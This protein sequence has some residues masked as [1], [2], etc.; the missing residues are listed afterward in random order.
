MAATRRL[1][2]PAS[3]AW[4]NPEQWET[5]NVI[6]AAGRWVTFRPGVRLG[7][8]RHRWR[9]TGS[10]RILPGSRCSRST[11]TP[12]HDHTGQLDA[13]PFWKAAH[14]YPTYRGE[15]QRQ[16]CP[17]RGPQ[18]RRIRAGLAADGPRQD[19]DR[20]VQGAADRP[21]GHHRRRPDR[22]AGAFDMERRTSETAQ[23]LGATVP[24]ALGGTPTS[25]S[26]DPDV[27]KQLRDAVTVGH[28]TPALHLA[29]GVRLQ[30]GSGRAR[31]REGRQAAADRDRRGAPWWTSGV[32]T[33]ALSSR[34]C[35]G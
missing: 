26:L 28:P 34:R 9:P 1:A 6:G 19:R 14:D 21:R 10:A 32:L 12:N 4:P 11:A 15:P 17:C 31:L 33:S 35:P 18:R 20:M 30:S 29:R 3:D 5:V 13:D 27:K 23:H 25:A 22:G 8:P 7:S 16:A 2:V 24:A